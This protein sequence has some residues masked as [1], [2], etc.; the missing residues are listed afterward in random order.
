MTYQEKLK[1]PRWQKKR[2]LILERDGW[3]CQQCRLGTETLHVHH[4]YYL[5]K[6]DPWDYPDC[7]LVTLCETCH[8]DEEELRREA[9]ESIFIALCNKG[10]LF[11]DIINIASTL[12]SSGPFSV[13]TSDI[14]YLIEHLLNDKEL[15]QK[16]VALSNEQKPFKF[17]SC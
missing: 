6:S 13:P 16:V 7:A 5:P 11:A 12:E 15:Q 9:T 2:L 14:K 4:K 10:F 3:L 17:F 1:D 8:K